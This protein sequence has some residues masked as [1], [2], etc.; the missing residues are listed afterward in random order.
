MKVAITG[1]SGLIGGAL[2][3]F[4]AA[5]GHDVVRLVR[6]PPKARDEARWDPESGRVDAKALE[7]VDAV[8]HLAGENIA[9]GRWSAGRTALLRASRVGPT[10]LLALTLAGLSQRPK[11]LVSTSAIG[12][13]GNRGDAWVSENDPPA[14]DFLGRLSAEWEGAADPARQAGIRVVHPRLGIV[15]SPAGGALGKMLLPFRMGLGGVVGPGTQYM[16]W[17]ALDDVVAVVRHLLERADLEGPVNTVAPEPVTNAAFTKTL[18]RVLGR[19]AV[20]PLPALAL[21]LAF[22]EMA[23]ATLLSSTRVRPVRLLS[24]GYRF[25]FPDLDSALRHELGR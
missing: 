12:Y 23:D 17:I 1:A 14:D 4:L 21:R 24:T 2:G 10:R 19:P 7:G 3:P 5:D 9:G 25:R 11:V 18:G 13:Y 8:V 6:R 22:G 16:S 15:L 20:V